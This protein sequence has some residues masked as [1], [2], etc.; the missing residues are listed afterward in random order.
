MGLPHSRGADQC[1]YLVLAGH[2]TEVLCCVVSRL[3]TIVG[4]EVSKGLTHLGS[5]RRH[6]SRS[7]QMVFHLLLY[8]P[9]TRTG[10]ELFLYT[11]LN[12]ASVIACLTPGRWRIYR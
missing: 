5:P 11:L 9:A 6:V 12:P 3:V 10:A 4:A 7:K 8:V 2:L 1:E